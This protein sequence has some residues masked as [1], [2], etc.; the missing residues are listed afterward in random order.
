[1]TVLKE[2][3]RELRPLFVT[4]DP[5]QRTSYRA[6]ELAQFDLWQP[7]VNIPV[8][9]GQHDKLWVVTSVSGFS[10]FLA[11]WMV[12]TRAAHDVLG[13]MPEVFAQYGAVP[14]LLVW[15]QEGCIG[16]WRQGRLVLT[17]EFQAF[18][19]T[20]GA[21]VKLCGPYRRRPWGPWP[22]RCA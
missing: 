20:L 2:R 18:R 7:D 19:G 11:G 21:A 3:V 5:S 8:G 15:D 16:Q 1:M 9:F 4:P 22:A 12:P 17:R 10:R 6:G 13:G 14:R